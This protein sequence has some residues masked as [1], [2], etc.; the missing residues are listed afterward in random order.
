LQNHLAEVARGNLGLK[1]IGGSD[2]HCSRDVGNAYTEFQGNILTMQE[3]V[4]ALKHGE[5]EPHLYELYKLEFDEPHYDEPEVELSLPTIQPVL[6][7]ARFA[8]KR[9]SCA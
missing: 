8:N 9:Y 2:A 5:Y 7:G 1:G 4:H 3:L 6:F